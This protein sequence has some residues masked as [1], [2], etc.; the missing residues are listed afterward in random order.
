MATPPGVH[1]SQ[2]EI[3][4]KRLE[5]LRELLPSARR[6]VIARDISGADFDTLPHLHQVASRLGF[7]LVEAGVSWG[8]GFSGV[9]AH[10]KLE[11][12]I[13]GQLWVNYGMEHIADQIT[14]FA[15]ERRIPSIFW[16]SELADR[17]TTLTYGVNPTKELG[18]ATDQLARVL[19][20]AKP[21]E[22]PVD[23]AT[24]YEL[25]VN[26]KAARALKITVPTSILVR[27]D[28]VIE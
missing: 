16:E 17:G 6:V 15:A 27:A 5:L 22:L 1:F 21:A 9:A 28:R 18:R 24:S 4:A 19:K 12:V 11:A 3:G 20:G 2:L 25:V 23:Q 14:R 26:G 7:D 10:E 13:S 8:T